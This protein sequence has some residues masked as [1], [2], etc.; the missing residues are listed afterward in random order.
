MLLH[1]VLYI[2]NKILLLWWF[3]INNKGITLI[4]RTNQVFPITF[5]LR[6]RKA[7]GARQVSQELWCDPQGR[8]LRSV[9]DWPIILIWTE[10]EQGR[11]EQ[12]EEDGWRPPSRSPCR[13]PSPCYRIHWWKAGRSSHHLHSTLMKLDLCTVYPRQL[14]IQLSK[15]RPTLIKPVF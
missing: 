2:L 8:S 4:T 1:P 12:G 9:S 14:I 7:G 15:G 3:L 6:Q 11:K 10:K 5:Q 13:P